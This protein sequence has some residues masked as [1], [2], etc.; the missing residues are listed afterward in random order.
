LDT[1]KTFKTAASLLIV[2]S[3]GY[4]FALE[5]KKNWASLQDFKISINTGYLIVSLSFYLLSSLLETYIWQVCMNKHLG[6][7]ELNFPRSVAV[8]NSSGLLKYLPGRIWTYTA[9]L[10][11][12]KK[13]GISKSRVLYVNLV[14]ILGSLI[15][16][17]Y[18]SLFYLAL[19]TNLMNRRA[20]VFTAALLIL[21][22]GA[23][24]IW[25]SAFMNKLIALTGKLLKKEIQPL[26]ESRPLILYIQFIYMCSWSLTGFGGYLLAKGIGLPV[27][28]TGIFALLASMSLSWL[29]GY[30]AVI[31]P[32]GLGI[33]EGVML[34]MLNNIVSVETALIFPLVSR[35]MYLVTDALLGLAA[36][37]LGMKYNIFSSKARATD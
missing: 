18:L 16:S 4:F 13:Y 37:L 36:L 5:F 6:R 20:F 1:R 31:S 32:G 21:F 19:Y 29:I 15:V 26:K 25:N 33:R 11:W 10:L 35:V 2:L 27:A 8:V 23:Y 34:V 24:I 17:L 28:S 7:H 9:Q 14:C 12:L 22:N 3:I 30:F